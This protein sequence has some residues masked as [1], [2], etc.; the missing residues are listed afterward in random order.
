MAYNLSYLLTFLIVYGVSATFFFPLAFAAVLKPLGPVPAVLCLVAYG[1]LSYGSMPERRAGRIWLELNKWWPVS[2]DYFPVSLKVWDGATYSSTPSAAHK[3]A[4]P[5]KFIMAMHPHG[6]FPVSASI[7][8]PQI[9]R[10]GAPLGDLFASVRFAAASA[11]FWLPLVRDMYLWLGCI[12]ASRRTLTQALSRGHSIAILP[13][14]E[15]EQLLVCPDESP[16]EDLVLPRDGL[17]RLALATGTPLIP[18]FSFGERR[19]YHS[20]PFLLKFR[21]NLMKKYR[22]GIPMAY[23][24]HWWFPFVPHPLPILIVIGKPV[25]IEAQVAD[26]AAISALRKRYVSAMEEVFEGN[27]HL[28]CVA[29]QKKLRWISQSA[30]EEELCSKER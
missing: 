13:G 1:Y 11:V 23:G 15:H 21:L 9:A 22:I 18:V 2:H 7:L 20:S 28:D 30:V 19:S 27:K 25:A 26:E 3:A 6:P 14:G 12:E 24:R 8:M 29:R 10:F 17:L 16:F 5:S 4:L